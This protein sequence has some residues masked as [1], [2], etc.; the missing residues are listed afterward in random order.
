MGIDFFDFEFEAPSG[1]QVIVDT[2]I[3]HYRIRFSGRNLNGTKIDESIHVSHTWIR[4][5]SEWKL[6]SGMAYEVEI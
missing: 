2:V 6:L 1:V 5:A 4:E 3:N